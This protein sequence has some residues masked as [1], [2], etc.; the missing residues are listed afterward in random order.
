MQAYDLA[1]IF[2]SPEKF[3]SKIFS[4]QVKKR[5]KA[6][7]T[8]HAT[9]KKNRMLQL[10]ADD[11]HCDNLTWIEWFNWYYQGLS[12]SEFPAWLQ[13][14]KD[15]L[16]VNDIKLVSYPN[17]TDLGWEIQDVVKS[18]IDIS[19]AGIGNYIPT[20]HELEHW[21]KLRRQNMELFTGAVLAGELVAQVGF[22]KITAA[23]HQKMSLGKLSENNLSGLCDDSNEE[24]FL[25]IPSVVIKRELQKKTLLMK[26]LQHLFQQFNN[27][28]IGPKVKGFIAIAYTKDGEKL[29]QQFNLSYKTSHLK[30]QKV[31]SGTADDLLQSKLCKKICR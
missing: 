22:I 26:M 17:L 25:Y 27:S 9:F 5:L 1:D 23:E 3:N 10:L 30:D 24:I 28:A 15:Q 14:A 7:L 19:A 29:C 31:Y 20:E 6:Y 12:F 13:D 18:S 21:V 8:H 4:A 16:S 11:F 2:E